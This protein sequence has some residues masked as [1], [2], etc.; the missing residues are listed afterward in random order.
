MLF[1]VRFYR[2]YRQ[3]KPL[4]TPFEQLYNNYNTLQITELRDYNIICLVHKFIHN[5][6]DLPEIYR[7]YFTFNSE[8]HSYNTRTSSN[9][10]IQQFNSNLGY[11]NIKILGSNLWNK[12]TKTIKIIKSPFMIK[13]KLKFI[14][15]KK[16]KN[17]FKTFRFYLIFSRHNIII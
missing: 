15:K 12:L 14:L 6:Q 5:L 11:G 1:L 4:K 13:R 3:S 9:L 16:K 7:S 2:S 8:I 17:A 10:H